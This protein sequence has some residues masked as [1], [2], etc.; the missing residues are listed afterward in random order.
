[1]SGQNEPEAPGL[2]RNERIK[3]ASNFLRGTIK[4]GL[5]APLTGSI[6]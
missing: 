4:E 1:M 6:A 5:D 2:S 3:T